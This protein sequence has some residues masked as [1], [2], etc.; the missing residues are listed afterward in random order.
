MN[1]FKNIK[2]EIYTTI[3]IFTIIFSF[4]GTAM[5]RASIENGCWNGNPNY[6]FWPRMEENNPD[7][8]QN[9]SFVDLVGTKRR[10]NVIYARILYVGPHREMRGRQMSKDDIVTYGCEVFEELRPDRIA[11]YASRE[12]YEKREQDAVFD[13]QASYGTIL[14][15]LQQDYF[16]VRDTRN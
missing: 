16:M 15:I 8:M 1:K 2:I 7:L 6:P 4:L 12:L 3:F 9:I 11:H 14:S 13:P 10:G 5:G